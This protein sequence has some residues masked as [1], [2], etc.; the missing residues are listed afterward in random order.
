MIKSRKHPAYKNGKPYFTAKRPGVY[1]I[2]Q[3][4]ELVYVGHSSYDLYKTM[5][6]HFQRWND[7]KQARVTYSPENTNIKVR[8]IYTTAIR[9]KKLEKALILKYQPKDNPEKYENFVLDKK[10]EKVLIEAEN[11]FT[12]ITEDLPF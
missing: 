8:V 5:Y 3:N 7:P 4:N 1:L 9:A 12:A 11:E 6:R 10:S 2:Y